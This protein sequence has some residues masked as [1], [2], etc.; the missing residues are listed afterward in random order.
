MAEIT[1]HGSPPVVRALVDAIR[2]AGARLA[3]PG[4]FTR[5]ALEGGKLDLTQAEAVRDL[6]EAATVEQARIAA[7][8]L[9]GEVASAL[10]PVAESA[11]ELLADVE[12][13]L[14]FSEDEELLNPGAGIA[15]RCRAV[16][17]RLDELVN[18]SRPAAR[19]KEGARVVL[20]GPPNAGKSS[21]F[22]K[23]VHRERVIVTPEPGTTRDLIEEVTV[24][25]GL[26]VVLVDGAGVSDPKGLAD[27]EAMRRATAAAGEADLVLEVRSL[28]AAT[29]PIAPGSLP[30]FTHRDLAP[31]APVPPQAVA[32][33]NV[34]GEG[35]DILRTR[36]A[37]RLEAPGQGPV[38]TV[39]LASERH[40]ER[41]IVAS[42]ALGRA[43]QLAETGQPLEMCAIELRAA[44]RALHEI[45]GHVGPEELL[46]RIFSRFCIG[47]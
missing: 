42:E 2:A 10:G 26:P 45:L 12:A 36:I 39:A 25:E 1:V 40:R 24:I 27:A 7:R 44:V 22:N 6:I 4:E 16:A 14:D 41:A 23:L 9:E 31:S 21:L 19:V 5:R 35:L 47:K 30:V 17:G 15:E 8:Q 18:A 33:S 20:L 34:S 38:D 28:T 29:A 32:V 13:D 46:G 37:E 11:V 3:E 43:A